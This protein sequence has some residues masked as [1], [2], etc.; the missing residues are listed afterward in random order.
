M[1]DQLRE[2]SAQAAKNH[3]FQKHHLYQGLPSDIRGDP[4]WK[5]HLQHE[6]G[7]GYWFWKAALV[8]RLLKSHEVNDGDTVVWMDADLDKGLVTGPDRYSAMLRNSG[9]DV[10]VKNQP[11][12]ELQWTKGDVFR[13]FG[14]EWSNPQYGTSSQAHAQFAIFKINAKT[15]QFVQHWE[16][17]MADWH[18]VSDEPSQSPNPPSFCENRH[19]Q[20]MISMLAKA[21]LAVDHTSVGQGQL[22][23]CS[24]AIGAAPVSHMQIK[25]SRHPTYG[26]PGLV[27]K[28]G[29]WYQE[30]LG[31]LG[32]VNLAATADAM[33]VPERTLCVKDTCIDL[34]APLIDAHELGLEDEATAVDW[35]GDE[36]E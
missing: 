10:F 23:K 11:F 15:R 35:K 17:L 24:Q 8:N 31:P 13:K 32:S 27:A 4:K 9:W 1:F 7:R 5:V 33:A 29:D 18:L 20:T 22:N 6:R 14:V 2:L 26:I 28:I 34:N 16:D 30:P 19:D 12:C 21:N 25:P 36:I 3:V